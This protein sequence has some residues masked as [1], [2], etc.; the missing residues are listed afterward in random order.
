MFIIGENIIIFKFYFIFELIKYSMSSRQSTRP[1]TSSSYNRSANS[2]YNNSR[3]AGLPLRETLKNMNR[4]LADESL[5]KGKY[6]NQKYF[7]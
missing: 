4:I 1:S 3:Y 6:K 2:S 5:S 7:E